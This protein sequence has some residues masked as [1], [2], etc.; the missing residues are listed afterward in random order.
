[1]KTKRRPLILVSAV[2]GN[3]RDGRGWM[4]EELNC[5]TLRGKYVIMRWRTSTN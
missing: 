5:R 4:W 1:M 2:S 3:P